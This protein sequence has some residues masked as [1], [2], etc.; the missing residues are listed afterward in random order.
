VR[1]HQ[2]L[3]KVGIRNELVTI[4]GGKHGGF[5]DAEMTNAYTAI[6]AFL[7]KQNI[8]RQTTN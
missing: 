2:A 5:S 8:V 1:L 7:D 3:D 6:R 4:P